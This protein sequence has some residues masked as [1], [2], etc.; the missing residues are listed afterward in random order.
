[1]EDKKRDIITIIILLAVTSLIYISCAAKCICEHDS[2]NF[3]GALIKFDL[4]AHNPHPPGYIFYIGAAKFLNIFIKN[5]NA[6]FVILSIFFG[7]ISVALIF[8]LGKEIF[9]YNCGLVSAI[10][11][12]SSPVFWAYSEIALSFIIDAFATILI[13]LLAYKV[14]TK[15]GKYAT[16]LSMALGLA[17]GFRQTLLILLFPLWLLSIIPLKPGKQIFK[18]FLILL[19]CCLVWAIPL[20]IISGG[21]SKYMYALNDLLNGCVIKTFT[22]KRPI[23]AVV[24]TL[25]GLSGTIIA[26][27]ISIFQFKKII[28]PAQRNRLFSFLL[29]WLGPVFF[30]CFLNYPGHP[31]HALIWLPAF[32]LFSSIFVNKKINIPVI[33]IIILINLGLFFSLKP[34]E[35]GEKMYGLNVGKARTFINFW[36]SDWSYKGLQKK[37]SN[38]VV[39]DFINS[40]FSPDT[41]VIVTGSTR[42]LQP[43]IPFR[44]AGYYLDKF[45]HFI[46]TDAYQEILLPGS[47]NTIVWLLEPSDLNGKI[48]FDSL[49]VPG[50]KA[51]YFSTIVDSLSFVNC[52][53][54][55]K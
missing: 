22:P 17:A 27:I 51:I 31:G 50:E 2:V 14:R 43:D 40:N 13:A 44:V 1:M 11:L 38:K 42:T 21:I 24:S 26:F 34:V 32:F 4:M 47:T 37:Q 36:F 25:Y 30:L 10:F 5:P 7:C 55:R 18:Q 20:L 49:A 52:S 33:T 28:P 53:F 6:D 41:A 3:A 9:N 29:S 35:S 23:Y 19:G 45:S 16:Y 46:I 39:L 15:G 48:E 54:Y 8:L 12:L